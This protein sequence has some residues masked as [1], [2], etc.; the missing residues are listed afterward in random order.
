MIEEN[1]ENRKDLDVSNNRF[2]IIIITFS[3]LIFVI[4]LLIFMTMIYNINNGIMVYGY[5]GQNPKNYR[6][7]ILPFAVIAKKLAEGKAKYR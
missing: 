2:K 1:R 7:N 4:M 5:Y 3:V 6:N